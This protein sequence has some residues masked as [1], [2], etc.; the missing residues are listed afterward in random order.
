MRQELK[1]NIKS[2]L[3]WSLIVGGLGFV[4]TL[5]YSTM[6]SQVNEL[7]DMMSKMGSFSDA[8]GMST[9]SIA[10]LKG[11]FATEVG[12]IHG[13]GSAMFAAFYASC[14]L[15]KEEDGHTGEFLYSL[16]VSRGK[17][18]TAKGISIILNLVFFTLI[19]GIFYVVGFAALGE[20]ILWQEMLRFL[21]SML[22]MNLEVAAIAFLLSAT[23]GR[24]RL[25][26]GL[27]V[28]L[29]VYAYD[30]M[31]RVVPSLKDYLFIGPFSFANASEIFAGHDVPEYSIPLSII[32]TIAAI[33]GAYLVYTRRD[34][35]G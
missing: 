35:A 9:L 17:V 23:T 32:V 4:C 16:P 21:G 6:D 8:F 31:G 26:L 27:G 12:V 13:L 7:A 19:C 14:M 30:L 10:T 11:Y 28:A 24:N 18:I 33:A 34:L 5:L 22:L 25:G 3:I 1:L 29:I 15:S 2:L 20:E